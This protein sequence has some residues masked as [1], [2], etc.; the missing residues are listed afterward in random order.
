M[1]D[2]SQTD[3]FEE[4]FLNTNETPVPD[5]NQSSSSTS[6]FSTSPVSS[7]NEPSLSVAKSPLLSNN[8]EEKPIKKRK[9]EQKT[10]S[11]EHKKTKQTPAYMRRN[12]RHLL[13]NDK[14]QGDTLS[15]LKAEQDRLKR[16]EEINENYQQFNPIYTHIPT[17]NHNQLEQISNEQEC[18]VLDDDEKEQERL[19]ELKINSSKFILIN[20]K[21]ER[22]IDFINCILITDCVL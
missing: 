22:S 10:D 16:L 6:S 12:I 20:C 8:E 19:S 7:S 5:A 17:N 18:I 11:N 15:A 14:L 2:V 21:V 13:T 4:W 1:D 3:A 9:N